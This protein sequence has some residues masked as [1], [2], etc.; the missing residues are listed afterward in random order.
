MKHMKKLFVFLL[1]ALVLCSFS[2]LAK[3]NV[4]EIDI[5]VTVRDDGSAYI[6]QN[7]TGTFFEGTENFAK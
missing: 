3:N 4:S 5:E 1:V 7:W 2:V 6:V